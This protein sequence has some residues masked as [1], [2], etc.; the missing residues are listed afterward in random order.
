MGLDVVGLLLRSPVILRSSYK[1]DRVF[2]SSASICCSIW[3]AAALSAYW[4]VEPPHQY[5][6]TSYYTSAPDY[7]VHIVWGVL[8]GLTTV[9][10]FG[11][12]YLL[13]TVGFIAF[14][15]GPTLK[16][17]MVLFALHHTKS[18][19]KWS[20]ERCMVV[21]AEAFWFAEYYWRF[22]VLQIAEAQLKGRQWHQIVPFS[23]GFC[24]SSALASHGLKFLPC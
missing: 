15:K 8:E 12:F 3:I 6:R 21:S 4:V 17:F 11:L 7:D 19:T 5:L 16:H 24:R 20:T 1:T 23:F 10:L 18:L 2:P 14:Q 9:H 22:V 13:N